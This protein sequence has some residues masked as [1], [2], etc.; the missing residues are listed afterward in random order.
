[1]VGLGMGIRT[2]SSTPRRLMSPL[3]KRDKST[4]C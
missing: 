4:G 1:V 3:E 2:Q